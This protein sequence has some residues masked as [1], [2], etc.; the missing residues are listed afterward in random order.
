M[1]LNLVEEVTA[2][3]LR[4][5]IPD[6]KA[7]DTVR[8][9]VRI[10]ENKKERIQN[11]EGVVIQRRGHGVSETFIIRKMSSGIGVERIFP[12]HS[13]SI[14]KIEVVKHGRVRR[15]RIHYM[16]GLAGK[17]ARIKEATK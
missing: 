15:A 7:G 11:Y 2:S 12:T 9:S 16:R 8:V 4:D 3:Q 5:D 17:A 14:A 6:F 13:P 10:I 1:N